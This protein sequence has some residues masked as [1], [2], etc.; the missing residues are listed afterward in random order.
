MCV[1]NSAVSDNNI[2]GQL[3]EPP[4]GG[5]W[6]SVVSRCHSPLQK[7]LVMFCQ[8]VG[9]SGKSIKPPISDSERNKEVRSAMDCGI[10]K[11]KDDACQI[12]L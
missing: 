3:E 7:K 11:E 8:V 1:K 6:C 2:S 5:S 10:L 9:I 12:D 4:G